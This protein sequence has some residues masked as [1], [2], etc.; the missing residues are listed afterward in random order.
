MSKLFHELHERLLRAGVAPRHVRRYLTELGEHLADLTAEEERAGR[1]RAEAESA[2]M[3]RLGSVEELARA[4]VEQPQ[5]QAWTARVPW[6]IFGLAPIAALAMAYFV[7]C[8]YLWFVW[9]I[10]L[11]AADSPF[12]AHPTGTVAFHGFENI[13]F[14]AGKYYYIF[15]P[16]LV[17]WGTALIAGRQRLKGVWP[18]VG[19]VLVALMG[20]TAQIHAGRTAV[21]GGL[22]HIRMDFALGQSVGR[23]PEGL[24]GALVILSLT[25]L[26]YFVWRLKKAHPLSA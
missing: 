13:C 25:A 6:A 8:C 10:F 17:G 5:F 2:A 18:G 20:G 15:A 19:L 26:P 1:S 22:G 4:M 21:S 23:I 14:Q 3:A 24:L 11:P 9:R 7:A 16:I 12:G